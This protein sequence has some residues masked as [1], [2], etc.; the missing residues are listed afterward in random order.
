MALAAIA[1]F[2]VPTAANA[3]SY[4]EEPAPGPSVSVTVPTG[5]FA[6]NE[7][8][9]ILLSGEDANFATVSQGI[10]R[11][12]YVANAPIGSVQ[13]NANGGVS[14]TITLPSTATGTY[15]VLHTSA[16]NP[17]GYSVTLT[18]NGVVSGGG[19]GGGGGS[20]LPPT[21]LDSNSLLGLWVGGG[22][23][24][25]AGGAVA[26]AAAVRRQRQNADA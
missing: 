5:T 6:A 12:A 25:L 19:T 14:H 10:V 2:A 1:L 9:N 7:T 23:L 4:P 26:V 3:N 11:A 21:G 24:V 13:S 22:A 16:S 17:G 15:T 8:V 18:A 20:A